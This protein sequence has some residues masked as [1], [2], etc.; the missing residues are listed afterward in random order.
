MFIDKHPM[1]RYYIQIVIYKIDE[2][3]TITSMSPACIFCNHTDQDSPLLSFQYQNEQYW[4]CPEHLP[5]LIHHPEQ[6][7]DKFPGFRSKFLPA[8]HS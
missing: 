6:L 7:A 5:I 3:N 1:M 4:I 8:E 2:G